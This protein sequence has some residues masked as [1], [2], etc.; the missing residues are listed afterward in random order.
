[1]AAPLLASQVVFKRYAGHLNTIQQESAG[2]QGL[3]RDVAQLGQ[4]TCFGISPQLALCYPASLQLTRDRKWSS[5]V[6]SYTL[7]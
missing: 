4:R 3:S 5:K 1:M 7:A 6:R 2:Q